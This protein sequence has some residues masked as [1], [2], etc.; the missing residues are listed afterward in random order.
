MLHNDKFTINEAIIRFRF[1]NYSLE[2]NKFKCI[3]SI[4]IYIYSVA[5]VYNNT[6]SNLCLPAPGIKS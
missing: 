4:Y 5:Q 3:C 2:V 6:E 1:I